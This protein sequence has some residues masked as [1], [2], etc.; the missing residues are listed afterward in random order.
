M[1]AKSSMFRYRRPTLSYETTL[2]SVERHC[3][4][5]IGLSTSTYPGCAILEGFVVRLRESSGSRAD[6]ICRNHCEDTMLK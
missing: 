5:G 6:R 4:D 1:E 3:R 2:G